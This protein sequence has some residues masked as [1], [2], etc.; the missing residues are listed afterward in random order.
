MSNA[1][2]NYLNTYSIWND[3]FAMINGLPP[4]IDIN[5]DAKSTYE[6]AKIDIEINRSGSEFQKYTFLVKKQIKNFERAF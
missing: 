3:E 6:L 2:C 4:L 1:N 5:P